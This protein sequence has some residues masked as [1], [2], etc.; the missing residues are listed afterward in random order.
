MRL[1]LRFLL[2]SS[3]CMIGLACVSATGCASSLPTDPPK[4]RH[5]SGALRVATFNIQDLRLHDIAD[6]ASDRIARVRDIV[7]AVE[8]DVLVVQ[9]IHYDGVVDQHGAQHLP[10]RAAHVLAERLS[11]EGVTYA[12]HVWPSNTGVHSG[13]DL[14]RNG[15]VTDQWGS[16]DFGGDALGYGE[17]PG[18]YAMAL[19]VR[20]QGGV[21][22]LSEGVRTFANLRWAD[23]PGAM[24]PVGV[25]E[26][27]PAGEPWYTPEMLGV[28][29]LSS[30]SHWDVPVRTPNG[31]TVHVL[32]SH[33]TPPVF[34]GG[35]DRNGRRNHDEIRFWAEYVG[36]GDATDDAWIVDDAGRAGGLNDKAARAGR[37]LVIGDLNADPSPPAGRNP[38]LDPVGRWLV[39][40]GAVVDDHPPR[41]LTDRDGLTARATANFG[42]RVDYVLPGPGLSTL[43]VGMLRGDADLAALRARD[44][45]AA[46]A[47]RLP[48]PSDEQGSLL[49]SAEAYPSDHFLVWRDVTV[50]HPK[51]SEQEAT[52]GA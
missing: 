27:V 33:P 16:R 7:R 35:E 17:F 9:E 52:G 19:L 21:E 23:M 32:I 28:M 50:R 38:G 37:Y 45:A 14:D 25:G 40:T 51:P 12:A 11:G 18:Q 3:V 30:K 49:G 41:S 5:Q 36:R 20:E 15:R 29:R 2:V 13:L 42:L 47:A 39:C 1:A 48:E 31:D 10:A 24:L 44:G 8:P 26:R 34:D 4:S 46:V 22:V 6:P 43:G